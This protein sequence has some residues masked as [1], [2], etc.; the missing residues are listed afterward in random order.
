[1]GKEIH[2]ITRPLKGSVGVG[3]MEYVF[4]YT[5]RVVQFTFG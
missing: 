5:R 3:D 1:M 4:K 2:A